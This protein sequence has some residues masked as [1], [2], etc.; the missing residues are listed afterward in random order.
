MFARPDP[1]LAVH[2]TE[3]D[4]LDFGSLTSPIKTARSK[5]TPELI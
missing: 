5:Q 1:A 4:Y 3:S 2:L